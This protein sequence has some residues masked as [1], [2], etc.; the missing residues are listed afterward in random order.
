MSR[1]LALT[2]AIACLTSWPGSIVRAAAH[3]DETVWHAVESNRGAAI[4]LLKYGSV[5][6]TPRLYLFTRLLMQTGIAP[7]STTARSG[8]Q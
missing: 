6:P 2:I 8:G 3:R 4:D 5:Y 7:L 1:I